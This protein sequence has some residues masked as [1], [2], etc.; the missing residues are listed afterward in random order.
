MLKNL[1]EELS[2]KSQEEVYEILS[3]NSSLIPYQKNVVW[4][5]LFPKHIGHMELP[6]LMVKEEDK[7]LLLLR[8][9][10]GAQYGRYIRH[11]LHSFIKC[12]SLIYIDKDDAGDHECS[13]CK[14][15][16]HPWNTSDKESI[17]YSSTETEL[18]TCASCLV[19]L[20]E[21]DSILKETDGEDY[22]KMW[23]RNY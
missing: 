20:K 15:V 16:L 12:P 14:R 3:K 17:A 10:S 2:G 7:K 1:L 19:H 13:V 22:L 23:K 5:R 18:K 11:L 9:Y 21:L 4:I 6:D 8:A